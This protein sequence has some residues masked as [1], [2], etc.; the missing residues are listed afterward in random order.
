M[1]WNAEVSLQ[2]FLIGMLGIGIGYVFHISIPVLLFCFTIVCMQLVEYFV[3]THYNDSVWNRNMSYA[4]VGLLWTQPIASILTIS[5]ETLRIQFLN[6]YVLLSVFS[7]LIQTPKDYSMTRAENGH[8]QWNWLTKEPSTYVSLAIYFIFLFTPLFIQ[9]SYTL[10]A[11][12]ISTLGLSV[13]TFAS[14]NTWGSMWCWIVN[15][16]VLLVVGQGIFKK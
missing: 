16:L 14:S 6:A 13:Y 5:N 2:S 7:L 12:A 3:W 1:C 15:V 4:A 9:K 11:L 8:L 10:L